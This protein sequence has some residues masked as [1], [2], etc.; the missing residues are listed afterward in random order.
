MLSAKSLGIGS[1]YVAALGKDT[2]GPR[3]I[4]G[5]P[6]DFE[7]VCFIPLGYFDKNPEPHD[8]K[9]MEEVTRWEKF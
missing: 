3:E 9:R 4:L 2:S 5:I 7:I 8:K 6:E 1:C